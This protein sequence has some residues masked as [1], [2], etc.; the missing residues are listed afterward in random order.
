MLKN[1]KQREE[2]LQNENNWITKVDTGLIRV[3]EC[4]DYPLIKTQVWFKNTYMGDA[5]HTTGCYELNKDG[6]AL[7]LIYDLS[8]NQQVA[9]LRKYD[10]QN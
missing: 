3:L 9:V 10:T 4:R 7:E 2:Y 1:N 8:I 5:Y 6:T